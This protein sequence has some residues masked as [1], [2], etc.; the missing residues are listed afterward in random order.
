MPVNENIIA[1]VPLFSDLSSRDIRALTANSQQREYAQG[2]TLITQGQNGV[3]LFVIT[4]G[5]VRV[6]QR[7]VNGSER[8][9]GTFARGAVLGEMSLL[10]DLPRSATVTALEPTQALIIPVWGFRSVLRE[11][12]EMA[13][14][15][16]EVMSR[17]LRGHSAT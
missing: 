15:L 6:T 3:G 9:L 17:R 13:I 5:T 1:Q 10:D 12:P 4:S 7:D 16:L 2:E 8:D 11:S 14:K